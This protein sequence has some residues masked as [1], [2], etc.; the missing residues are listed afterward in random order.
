MAWDWVFGVLG[1]GFGL[2]ALARSSRFK[3]LCTIR[4]WGSLCLVYTGSKLSSCLRAHARKKA[5]SKFQLP[6]A[7][8]GQEIGQCPRAKP[9]DPRASSNGSQLRAS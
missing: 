6:G 2:L 5:N 3:L 7:E 8:A 9:R 4:T 1:T